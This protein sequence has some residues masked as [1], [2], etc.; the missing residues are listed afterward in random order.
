ME[1]AEYDLI[2]SIG[3]GDPAAFEQLIKRY[4]GPVLNFVYRHL[5]DRQTAEDL[6]QEV[7]L[8]VFRAAS[9]FEPRG[10]VRAWIFT[11]ARNLCINEIKRLERFRRLREEL[12]V[13]RS[14]PERPMGH[15]DPRNREQI[16]KLMTALARLPE[17]QRTALL[18]RANEGL[19]YAEIAEVLSVSVPAVES[20]IHRARTQLRQLWKDTPEE[21]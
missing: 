17:S 5:W 9:G 14:S 2:R 8:R 19:R 1:S 16:E 18:L 11:I 21:S 7:F 10:G 4:E 6:T 13:R 12:G 3:E 15:D 20:L